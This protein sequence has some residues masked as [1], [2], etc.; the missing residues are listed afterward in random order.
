MAE[1]KLIINHVL[2]ICSDC[3]KPIDKG[4]NLELDSFRIEFNGMALVSGRRIDL[5]RMHHDSHRE[6][7]YRDVPQHNI[8]VLQR[9]TG[10][11]IGQV[12]VS[13][14]EVTGLAME[15]EDRKIG[16][17]IKKRANKN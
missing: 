10:E 15:V 7:G 14:M 11:K 3:K 1:K 16:G 5:C 12:T 4:A 2:A 9:E 17:M 8:F 13:S 6:F